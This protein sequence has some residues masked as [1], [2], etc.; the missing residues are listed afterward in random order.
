MDTISINADEVLNKNGQ[1]K[2]KV[3]DKAKAAMAAGTAG[4]AAGI[5]GM[6]MADAIIEEA[7][8][9]Q[10][11]VSENQHT[12]QENVVAETE[13]TGSVAAD[14]NPGDVM[15][16][17][18][19]AEPSAETDMIAEAHHAGEEYQPFANNDPIGDNVLL[20]PHPE[21]ILIAENTDTDVV[22]EEDSMVDMICGMPEEETVM[23]EEI[24]YPEDDL[25]ADNG[26]AYGESDVQ[27]DLM[28]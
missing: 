11:P 24:V 4:V 8:E 16:E 13:T 20:E 28:A 5:A 23:P 14:V 17:E 27:S 10:T 3:S 21:E 12:Q 18:P 7:G 22:I 2:F 15:L 26:S 1:E 9:V 19:V 6:S 25:Y